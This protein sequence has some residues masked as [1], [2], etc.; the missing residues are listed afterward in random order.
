MALE[1]LEG[2]LPGRTGTDAVRVL[3]ARV[4][5]SAA[6]GTLAAAIDHLEALA[7]LEAGARTFPV[8]DDH[9]D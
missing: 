7:G 4:R 8:E 6:V 9:R 1:S 3:K 5:L 2:A